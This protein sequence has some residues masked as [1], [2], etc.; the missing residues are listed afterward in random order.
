MKRLLFLIVGLLFWT[1]PLWAYLKVGVVLPLS[2]VQTREGQV[3]Q[4]WVNVLTS[5]LWSPGSIQLVFLD[6]QGKASRMPAVVKE[7]FVQGVDVLIGP[8][9]PTGAPL[10]AQEA[11]KL[12][13]PL[14]LTAGEINPIKQINHPIGKVFRTGLSTRAAVKV[15]FHCL[16]QKGFHQIGLLI[17]NDYWGREGQHWLEAYA[18]EYTLKIKA[19]RFF[20]PKDTDVTFQLNSL[21]DTQAIV[22][23][24]GPWASLT[25]ARNADQLGLKIP[26]FFSHHI[27]PEGFL[28]TYPELQ[29][30]PFVG[31]AFLAPRAFFYGNAQIYDLLKEFVRTENITY[32]LSLASWADAFLLL[33]RGEEFA[34]H[35]RLAK[36]LTKVGLLKG[37]TGYYFISADDH[38]GLLAPTVGVYQ[39][40]DLTYEPVCKPNKNS[41]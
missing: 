23:W 7:A 8:A 35:H 2:G 31:A 19:T 29:G 16:H 5:A 3:L 1:T 33:K 4:D 30:K 22:C 10:L 36:G 39:Y 12:D 38:Y 9:R 13:L 32:D 34:L 6:S 24:A 15:L 28:Q 20:G 18:A 14:I 37:I 25:V 40:Q 21:L 11:Q 17:S 27:S 26:I 41:F